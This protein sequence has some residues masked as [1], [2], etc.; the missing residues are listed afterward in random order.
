M[1]STTILDIIGSTVT[2]G[3]LL[4][5]A[6]R[7]NAS[8]GESTSAYYASYMLQT[9]MLTLTT[10]LEDDLKHVGA[11][12]APIITDPTAIRVAAANEFSFIRDS[13]GKL[14]DWRVG[15]STE[16]NSPTNPHL[17]YVYRNVNGVQNRFNLGVTKMT[18]TYWYIVD[19]T[20]VV[21]GGLP[22]A[23]ASFGNIG[24]IDISIVLE[25][26]Y[27][28]TQQYMMDTSEY[29]MY[30]RQIRSVARTTLVQMP[31]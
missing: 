3:I 2:F 22:I 27:K 7:L 8:A 15:D 4:I 6:L 10:L 26:P 31:P 19:P 14:I 20:V 24:P 5:I 18:F 23:K 28:R 30:W 12:Y 17:R 9:N 13:D 21:P 16:V 1:G 11:W 29:E 25:S